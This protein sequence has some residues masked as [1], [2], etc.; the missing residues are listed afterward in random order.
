[1]IKISPPAVKIKFEA[2][3]S[4]F[5]GK[6]G[7]FVT[8]TQIE[9]RLETEKSQNISLVITKADG[10]GYYVAGRGELQLSILIE[11]LRR[12]GYE[13]QV[14]KPEIVYQ[15]VDGVMCEPKEE[16]I[17][18][19]LEGYIGTIT[20]VLNKR[21]AE[22]VNIETANDQT[23]MTYKILTRNLFGLRSQ[24][25]TATKGN[26]VLNSYISEY[27]KVVHQD[28][29]YRKGVLIAS[30]NGTAVGYALNTA[31]ERGEL[32]VGPSVEVY[33]GMIVGIN[34]YEQDMDVNVC[35][36]R[37]KS[38]V[39]LK[40]AE[41]TITSLRP[42]V[43]LTLEF[44]LVFLAK[45]EILEIT[46]KNLRLRKAFLTKNERVWSK[47]DSLTAFAKQQMGIKD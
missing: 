40:Q 26:A 39:R 20:D 30:E 21:K 17:I 12:E 22:L 10:G 8:A 7:K 23:R 24:L 43:E 11:T 32:F 46:P 35:K 6:E 14:R 4:P 15:M 3:T 2:N 27:V 25:L 36:G 5:V 44:A 45:D 31:Q 47:R 34:K 37:A 1:M 13:F 18:D 19:T 9:Q 38:G 16:L 29:L 33:E 28:E 41:I 42:V